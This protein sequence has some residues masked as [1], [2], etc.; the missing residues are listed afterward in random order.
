VGCHGKFQD[1]LERVDQVKPLNT[2]LQPG[3]GGAHD[4]GF[5]VYTLE[6]NLSTLAR[7]VESMLS[8]TRGPF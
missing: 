1:L 7:R 2:N 6:K 5:H 3:T 4:K 8:R